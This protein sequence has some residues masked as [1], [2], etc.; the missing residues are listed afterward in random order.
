M[1]RERVDIKGDCTCVGGYNCKHVVAVL[2][3]HL[4]QQEKL[5]R[6]ATPG[7]PAGSVLP[8]ALAVWLQR[9]AA[10]ARPKPAL[11]NRD[12]NLAS[13]GLIYVLA[14]DPSG[15][16]VALCLCRARL[17]QNGEV[18]S[19]QAVTE[20]LA[21]LSNGATFVHSIDED[22]VRLFVAMRSGV[23]SHAGIAIEPKGPGRCRHARSVVK[24]P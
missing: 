4:R 8:N 15:K 6:P 17:R 5:A 12:P 1:D 13:N 21:M 24:T 19:A 7:Q 10:A 23:D 18:I 9:L 2:L 11:E 14:P 16:H 20:V 3:T 22:L